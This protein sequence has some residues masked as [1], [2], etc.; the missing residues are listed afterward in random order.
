LKYLSNEK[1]TNSSLRE[2][3]G[4]GEKNYP[5]ASKIIRDTLNEELIKE[6]N[7]TKEYI[8]IWA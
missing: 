6:S 3:F 2:R 8:P 7:K 5:A 1:M 4:I